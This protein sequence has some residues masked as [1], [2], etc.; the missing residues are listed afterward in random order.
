MRARL[1]PHPC[2]ARA[3]VQA[4]LPARQARPCPHLPGARQ[5]R[6]T[7]STGLPAGPGPRTPRQRLQGT[8]P[9]AP[10]RPTWQ[11]TAPP[12]PCPRRW[13]RSHA[14][15]VGVRRSWPFVPRGPAWPA[16]GAPHA[17]AGPAQARPPC[18]RPTTARRHGRPSDGAGGRNA[19][20]RTAA[21]A[22]G[23]PG[24][25]R[26][27]A[28]REKR[29]RR[30]AGRSLPAGAHAGG[31][32][33]AA[34][35]VAPHT[36]ARSAPVTAHASHHGWPCPPTS[37]WAPRRCRSQRSPLRLPQPPLDTLQPRQLS[38]MSHAWGE[39]LRMAASAALRCAARVG[40]RLDRARTERDHRQ[41]TTRGRPAQLR[42]M[43]G[44]AARDARH[45][46]GLEQARRPR[47]ATC[48]WGREPHH[49]CITGPPGLGQTLV[50]RCVGA[51]G[52][53]RR[54]DGA[55]PPSPPIPPRTGSRQGGWTRGAQADAPG[56]DGRAPAGGRGPRAAP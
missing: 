42:Q 39:P 51:P 21:A 54:L 1:R 52:L 28:A 24:L 53:A 37:P 8:T 20:G 13:A 4:A 7:R 19:G 34:S 17:R 41:L 2:G 31:L 14:T 30:A 6:G 35:R 29:G 48:P 46:R 15:D 32:F 33:L 50:G 16:S 55:L 23:V 56:P 10:W 47:R 45:A 49:V 9:G 11:A 27:P 40:L 3:E 26:A 12:P 22:P 5:G 44:I 38:A 18:P 25:G 36:R 43:A